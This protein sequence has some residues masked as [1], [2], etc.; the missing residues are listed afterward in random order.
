MF[1]KATM[2][3]IMQ[4]SINDNINYINFL[5]LIVLYIMVTVK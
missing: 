2:K 4:F 5:Q 1:F 3:E